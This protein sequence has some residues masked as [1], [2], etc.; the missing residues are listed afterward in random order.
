MV[1]RE[2][3]IAALEEMAPLTVV[4]TATDEPGAIAWLS[5]PANRC[6]LAVLDIVLGRGSGLGVLRSLDRA[7]ASCKRVV[8][9]NRDNP[10][11]RSKCLALGAN[12]VFDKSVD[13]DALI[14]YCQ[15]LATTGADSPPA[16]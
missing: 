7:G 10:R 13:I 4:G 2:N 1:I 16:D 9:T 14:A 6:D 8:L 12:R 15:S 11:L 3:L 5:N